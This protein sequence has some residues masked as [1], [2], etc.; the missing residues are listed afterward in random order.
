MLRGTHM[1]IYIEN[2]LQ[3]THRHGTQP[4]KYQKPGLIDYK[5]IIFRALEVVCTNGLHKCTQPIFWVKYAPKQTSRPLFAFGYFKD[6]SINKSWEIIKSVISKI[7]S[8]S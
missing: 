1:I 3:P 7:S 4:C 5:K 6:I 8:L 2:N